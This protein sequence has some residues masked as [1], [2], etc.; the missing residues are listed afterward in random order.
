[1]TAI[2]DTPSKRLSACGEIISLDDSN[3]DTPENYEEIC[4]GSD[5]Y[6]QWGQVIGSWNDV[7]RRKPKNVKNLVRKG[8]PNALRGMVW[9][10]LSGARDSPL[11]EKYPLL[12]KV[13]LAFCSLP[14]QLA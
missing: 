3:V 1:M 14:F 7:F 13:L 11:K 5:L 9:Q 8:I 6:V 2:P 4:E 12:I 10:L